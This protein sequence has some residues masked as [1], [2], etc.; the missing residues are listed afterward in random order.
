M[1][2]SSLRSHVGTA[3]HNQILDITIIFVLL[4][5]G[6]PPS[7]TLG[8]S[9]TSTQLWATKCTSYPKLKLLI[10]VGYNQVPLVLQD[11]GVDCHHL[12]GHLLP[13]LL[14]VPGGFK[15]VVD[16]IYSSCLNHYDSF[17][18]MQLLA[19]RVQSNPITFSCFP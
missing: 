17:N 7:P 11:H 16:M 3:R 13:P 4:I 8:Y 18:N 2:S 12:Q 14:V 19:H 10:K 5:W 6:P 1:W 15:V 9:A